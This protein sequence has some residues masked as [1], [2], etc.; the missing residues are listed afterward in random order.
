MERTY[1]KSEIREKRR[2]M[3]QRLAL[4]QRQLEAL[5]K[6]DEAADEFEQAERELEALDREGTKPEQPAETTPPDPEPRAIGERSKTILMDRANIWLEP[7]DILAD[8]DKRKWVD[9]DHAHAI[10]RLRHALRRLAQ[11]DP[12]V[13]RDESGSTYRYRY[14]E[15]MDGYAPTAVSNANGA[16]YPALQGGRTGG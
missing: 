13:E 14:V 5:V 7:R 12:N 15:R 11:S 3:E 16:Q 1:S 6:M 10:Q 2:A 8:M 9:T 4:E